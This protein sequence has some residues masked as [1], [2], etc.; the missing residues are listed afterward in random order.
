MAYLTMKQLLEAGVHFGHQTKRWNP[1]M[2]PYIFAA[3]NGIYI[4][5]LQQT[6]KM[7]R[8]AYDV[9]R[10]ISSRGGKVLFIG[11]KKQA[12]TAIEEEAQRCGMPYVNQRWLG[13]MLTNFSTIKEGVKRLK[14]LE[15]LKTSGRADSLVKKEILK[16]DRKRAKLEKFL[17]GI[18]DMDTTPD[19]VFIVD[20][21]KEG[22]ALKEAKK[23]GIPIIAIVDTNCD[24]DDVDYIVP[25]NDDAI[26]AIKLFATAIADACIEGRQTYEESLEATVDKDENNVE[27]VEEAEEDIEEETEEK[28]EVEEG[29]DETETIPTEPVQ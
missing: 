9:I 19:A 1:K 27:N 13:G 26:R 25:G 10:D 3:R 23:L 5:D 11:T 21:K 8:E 24:P 18:K 2:K 16:L 28:G 22:I 12:Q 29:N 14:D 6:V 4:V 7:F 15:E 17:G 20:S